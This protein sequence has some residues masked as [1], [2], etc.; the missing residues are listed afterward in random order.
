MTLASALCGVESDVLRNSGASRSAH[1]PSP[2]DERDHTE[3]LVGARRAHCARGARA[4]V[5]RR[6]GGG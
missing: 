4:A 2:T 3:M 6:G 1:A 5:R